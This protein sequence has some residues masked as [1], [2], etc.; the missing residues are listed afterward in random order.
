MITERFIGGRKT[1][2]FTLQWHLTNACEEHCAHCYDRRDL[3]ILSPDECFRVFGDFQRFCASRRA[4]GQISLSGGN[5]LF[6]P[7]FWDIYRVIVNAKVKVT[8]L[9]NPIDEETIARFREIA[10]PF[11]YQVSIEGLS[12]TNDAIR[13]KGHFDRAMQFLISA[14]R[15][16]MPAQAMLTLSSLNMEET[17]PLAEKLDEIGISFRF[18]RLCQVGEGK[19]IDVPNAE[20]YEAFLIRYLESAREHPHM[21]MK[22]NLFNI[23]RHCEKRSHFAGCTGYGCGAAFN[24]VALLP[25]GE[26]HACRKFPSPIGDIREE[27]LGAIYNSQT[28]ARYRSGPKACHR[29]PVRHCRGCMAALYGAGKDP[30]VDL[31][32]QCFFKQKSNCDQKS[33]TAIQT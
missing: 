2:T 30:L 28:A 20:D 23:I 21:G 8:I 32:P 24:F 7:G 17:I 25:N 16:G 29:C 6:Y 22:D 27:S 31:D 1:G 33:I 3:S 15:L 13:G 5:P 12:G 9:G 10:Y 14:K 4:R 19:S 26:V 18:N 11:Y